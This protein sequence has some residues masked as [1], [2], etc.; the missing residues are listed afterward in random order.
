MFVDVSLILILFFRGI[1]WVSYVYLSTKCILWQPKLGIFHK[2]DISGQKDIT[3]ATVPF[4]QKIP[5]DT[6]KIHKSYTRVRHFWETGLY[7]WQQNIEYFMENQQWLRLLINAIWRIKMNVYK[8]EKHW[9]GKWNLQGFALHFN[10]IIEC[11]KDRFIRKHIWKWN[12][13]KGVV[14]TA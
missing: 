5:Q 9:K 6:Q 3:W 14:Q 10:E 13:K 12:W 8:W 1:F 2:K 7:F 4:R 11:E